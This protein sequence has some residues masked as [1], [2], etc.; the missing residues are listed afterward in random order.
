MLNIK[1]IR[2]KKDF[3]VQ[4]LKKR[5]IDQA[6]KIID[7]VIKLDREYRES[8]ETKEKL[9]S[10]RNSISKDLG[11]NKNDENKFKELSKKVT[12]LKD[13]ILKLENIINSKN[14]SLNNILLSYDE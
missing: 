5:N 4:S 12:S 9:L 2:V 14:K 13:E 1:D 3:I 11:I 10:E 7:D 8:L 6:D